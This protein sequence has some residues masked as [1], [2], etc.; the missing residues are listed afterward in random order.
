MPNIDIFCGFRSHRKWPKIVFT[1][2]YHLGKTGLRVSSS[3]ANR[4]TKAALANVAMRCT[5]F[6]LGH[7]MASL[8]WFSYLSAR[9]CC[10]H[11]F[12]F[13][14]LSHSHMVWILPPNIMRL[15]VDFFPSNFVIKWC[16]RLLTKILLR[17]PNLEEC[18]PKRLTSAIVR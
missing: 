2:I 14:T 10:Q 3:S 15:V 4:L 12:N 8:V 9:W 6:K 17:K 16:L 13:S 7:Q 18:L 1:S 5:F 11:K